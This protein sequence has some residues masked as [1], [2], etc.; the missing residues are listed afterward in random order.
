M[1]YIR[2]VSDARV[3][4]GDPRHPRRF[5]VSLHMG[6]WLVGL[7]PEA[8]AVAIFATTYLVIAIG[9]LPGFRL[10]RA[11]A[12]L[13]GAS[14]MVAV[15]ALPIDDVPKAIDFDTIVLLLGV[16]IVAANLLLSGFFRLV[17]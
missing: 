2:A 3:H 1:R 13:V 5:G 16:M 9:R 15:G 12:A 17:N 14:L 4:V 8:A 7:L 11:G 6:G 10:D